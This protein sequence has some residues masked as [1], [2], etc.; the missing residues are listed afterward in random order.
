MNATLFDLPS[1]A[2]HPARYTDSILGRIAVVLADVSGRVLDPFAGTGRIHELRRPDLET[3]GVE[4]EPEW[5]RW[6][7]RTIPT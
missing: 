5:Q 7:P 6:Q 2:P 4:I 1:Q 3:F